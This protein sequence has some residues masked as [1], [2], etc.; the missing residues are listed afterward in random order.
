MKFTRHKYTIA[1]ERG[2]ALT[3]A[4]HYTLTSKD[5]VKEGVS[6][7]IVNGAYKLTLPA[8]AY[9]LK[10][11]SVLVHCNNGSGKVAVVAGFGGG[12][13]NYDT[14]TPGAYCTVEFYCNGSYWY[15]LSDAVGAS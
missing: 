9:E 1:Q 11:V 7:V 3:K 13:G 8:A 6:F 5:I 14:V 10:G 4:G 15:A 12:G 2:T